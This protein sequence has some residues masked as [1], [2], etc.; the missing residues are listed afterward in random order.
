[1]SRT[2]SLILGASSG[3]GRALSYYLTSLNQDI[4]LCSRGLRDLEAM[5]SDISAKYSVQVNYKNIDLS[6]TAEVDDLFNS[7]DINDFSEIYITIGKVVSID[8]GEQPF[9]TVSELMETNYIAPVRIINKIFQNYTQLKS[10][11][12]LIISSIAVSRPRGKKCFFLLRVQ[13]VLPSLY[14]RL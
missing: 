11:K 8:N 6:N 13:Q 7:I 5:A 1:M 3:V 9:T 14:T 12:I 4:F 10:L 2:K